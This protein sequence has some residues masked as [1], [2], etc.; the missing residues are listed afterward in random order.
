MIGARNI[1]D[2]IPAPVGRR[3]TVVSAAAEIQNGR[4]EVSGNTGAAADCMDVDVSASQSNVVV[5]LT[6]S[7]PAP[8]WK[9]VRLTIADEIS[10]LKR[11]D[12]GERVAAIVKVAY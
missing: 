5:E 10:I 6:S 8:K 3:E 12:S 7:E 4:A 9:R 1:F 2:Q 11:L